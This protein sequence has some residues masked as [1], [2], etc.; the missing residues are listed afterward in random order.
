MQIYNPSGVASIP[1]G[2]ITPQPDWD[3]LNN[4][5]LSG[6]LFPI[7]ERLN[8][9]CLVNPA[10][11]TLPEIANAQNVSTA[12]ARIVTAVQVTRIEGALAAAL[13]M[14]G[15]SSFE[16]TQEEKNLW[17]STVGSLGFS[18]LVYQ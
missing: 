5:V 6:A 15:Y 8:I 12:V 18:S 17:N 4:A 13:S 11:A 1:D 14:L 9:A 16:F 3:G 2:F 7:Y 10:T